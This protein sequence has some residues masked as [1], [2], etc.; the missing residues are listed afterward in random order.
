MR[1]R[2]VGDV[3]CTG[4]KIG[5][6]HRVGGDRRNRGVLIDRAW[7]TELTIDLRSWRAGRQG[8]F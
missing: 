8:Y 4:C 2:T 7:A 5:G 6:C 3:T 1:F